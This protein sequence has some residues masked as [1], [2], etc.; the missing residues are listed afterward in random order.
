MVADFKSR[1]LGVEDSQI[2]H[3]DRLAR[4][5]LVMALYTAV[6]TGLW[7]AENNPHRPK[8]RPEAS[9]QKGRPLEHLLVHQS[10]ALHRPPHPQLTASAA[11]LG[12]IN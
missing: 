2:Q 8:K 3:P 5:L 6:S 1:G 11:P 12:V 10:S 9:A 7:D 4:L